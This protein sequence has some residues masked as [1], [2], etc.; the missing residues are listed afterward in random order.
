[1]K[2][3]FVVDLL[4]LFLGEA[5]RGAGSLVTLRSGLIN[6]RDGVACLPVKELAARFGKSSNNQDMEVI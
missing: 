2:F 4:P 5:R 1:M 6:G 3:G